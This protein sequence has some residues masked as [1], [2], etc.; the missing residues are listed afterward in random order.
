MDAVAGGREY[1]RAG[2]W[3]GGGEHGDDGWTVL[4]VSS[5][6]LETVEEFHPQIAVVLNI[7]PDHLDRHGT[8]ENYAAAKARIFAEQTA[9]DFLVLN[10]EDTRDADGC[11][12]DEGAGVLVQRA[13]GPVKQG[14]FVHGESVVYRA[15]RRTRRRSR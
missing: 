1:W 11:G 12:R 4:E 7:T 3:L 15:A 6:Q 9:E 14:A 2:D 8:F 13:S 10:G 5:F